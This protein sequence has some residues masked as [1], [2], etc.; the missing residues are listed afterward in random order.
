MCQKTGFLRI[1]AML[2]GLPALQKTHNP[3]RDTLDFAH[4]PQA[5]S[6]RQCTFSVYEKQSQHHA[7]HNKQAKITSIKHLER[8]ELHSFKNIQKCEEGY[9]LE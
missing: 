1:L 6:A 2:G 5:P 8:G 3:F 9:D 7:L 4:S